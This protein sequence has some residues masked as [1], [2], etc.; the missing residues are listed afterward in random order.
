MRVPGIHVLLWGQGHRRSS[1]I[2]RVKVRDC[3]AVQ[4]CP[5]KSQLLSCCL[6][7]L[8]MCGAC[9]LGRK[10][11]S[12]RSAEPSSWLL[13]LSSGASPCTLGLQCGTA[14]CEAITPH[15]LVHLGTWGS[16]LRLFSRARQTGIHSGSLR[17]A[18]CLGRE[19]PSEGASPGVHTGL[20]GA[21][22]C[23]MALG[24]CSLCCDWFFNEAKEISFEKN[25]SGFFLEEKAVLITVLCKQF[26][27]VFVIFEDVQAV[28]EGS[29][30]ADFSH[31][32]L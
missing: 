5:I 28:T 20:F 7:S 14:V 10:S 29:Y 21:C 24:S 22:C 19:S 6:R 2:P 27:S 3:S 9:G 8:N 15:S 12:A 18:A 30:W 1:L 16:S 31:A 4:Y 26:L 25:Q 13:L 23:C 32:M 11:N 17:C